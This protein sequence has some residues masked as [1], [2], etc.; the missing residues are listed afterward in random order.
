[1][2]TSPDAELG[3][4]ISAKFLSV[5]VHHFGKL[6]CYHQNSIAFSF[7]DTGLRLK[8]SWAPQEQIESKPNPKHPPLHL[9]SFRSTAVP[10]GRVT[11]VPLSWATSASC[12][13]VLGLFFVCRTEPWV[14]NMAPGACRA[15][16]AAWESSWEERRSHWCCWA[17]PG[18]W[19]PLVTREESRQDCHA[20]GMFCPGKEANWST[21][22]VSDLSGRCKLL[23]ER[24]G[25]VKGCQCYEIEKFCPSEWLCPRL[26]LTA[27]TGDV[28]GCAA[29]RKRS[30]K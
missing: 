26:L 21:T 13:P 17:Q 24:G 25:Y 29:C 11:R 23:A 18:P 2:W 12:F 4:S 20:H 15:Q 30:L 7:H 28:W 5:Y 19:S 10:H 1:M 22:G 27:L 3:S 9:C 8:I 16:P 6:S 14:E